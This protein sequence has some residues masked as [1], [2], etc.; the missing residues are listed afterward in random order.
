MN[1][2]GVI[3]NSNIAAI[4]HSNHNAGRCRCCT[5]TIQGPCTVT[6][7]QRSAV[8]ANNT[9]ANLKGPNKTIFRAFPRF[10]QAG[11]ILAI[12]STINQSVI[13]LT[14]NDV[15]HL[16]GG[17]GGVEGSNVTG[18]TVHEIGTSCFGSSFRSIIGCGG[19]GC[20]GFGCGGFG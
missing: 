15:R 4:S 3:A 5:H 2:E 12:R 6:C 10:C 8:V 13:Q 16:I 11:L 1:L 18:Q 14:P 19:F 20:E 7:G 17:L 9:F